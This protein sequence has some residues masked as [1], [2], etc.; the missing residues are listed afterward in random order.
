M[1]TIRYSAGI[2]WIVLLC[3]PL[4]SQTSSLVAEKI[5]TIGPGATGGSYLLVEIKGVRTD[6]SG[7]IYVLDSLRARIAK[8][9]PFGEFMSTIGK[10]LYDVNSH[11]E[12]DNNEAYKKAEVRKAKLLSSR[13]TGELSYPSALFV[14]DKRILVT[15][16]GKLVLYDLLGNVERV[17]T[18]KEVAMM[19]AAFPNVRGE[20]VLMGLAAQDSMFHV[21]DGA[22]AIARSFGDRFA[23]PPEISGKWSGDLKDSKIKMASMPISYFVGLGEEILLL[24]PFRYEINIFRGER[25]WKTLTGSS[26]Y[27]SGFTGISESYIGGKLAGLI[28]GS[29]AAPVIL[30]RDGLILVFQA[31]DRG[32]TPSDV[33]RIFRV[34]VFK[35]YKY[36]KSFDLELEGYPNYL[37][38]KGHLFTIGSTRKPFVNE[39]VLKS[40]P[41]L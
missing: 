29:I 22:G 20:L 11:N 4:F 40:L 15:D 23:V 18:P 39:Y 34:D 32:A 8:F 9:N 31:N 3:A 16:T 12:L 36:F 10:P 27:S 28:G 6:S 21:L 24:N 37:G 25:L 33:Q 14:D 38:P 30:E 13:V 2:F 19:Y 7:N 35:D 26:S 41:G 5:L 17:V 1:R